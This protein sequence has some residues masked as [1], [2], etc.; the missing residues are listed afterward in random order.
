MEKASYGRAFSHQLG[1]L[2]LHSRVVV[3]KKSRAAGLEK[4]NVSVA[5]HIPKVGSLCFADGDR[6]RVI[7]G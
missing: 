6:E 4:I 7:E 3:A 1:N 2:L 5:V